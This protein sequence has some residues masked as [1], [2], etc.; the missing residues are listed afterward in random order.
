L[1]SVCRPI[2]VQVRTAKLQSIS[3]E[4]RAR[5]GDV[6]DGR[7]FVLPVEKVYRIST[8]EE[9]VDAVTLPMIE[10]SV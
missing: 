9:D 5:T 10:G 8:G 3:Q 2:I 4:T 7:I 6:G 1:F